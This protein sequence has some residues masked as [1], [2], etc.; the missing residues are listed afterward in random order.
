MAFLYI[1]WLTKSIIA[2]VAITTQIVTINV[3]L[4]RHSFLWSSRLMNKY[5]EQT[6]SSQRFP[7]AQY[8]CEPMQLARGLQPACDV[9]AAAGLLL[10]NPTLL[11]FTSTTVYNDFNAML[12]SRTGG[13]FIYQCVSHLGSVSNFDLMSF[14]NADT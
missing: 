3:P 9:G 8:F 11:D 7:A 10:L 4:H 13:L 14:S 2:R 5:D 12:P 1:A 6:G